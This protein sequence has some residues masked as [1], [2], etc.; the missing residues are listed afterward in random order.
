MSI[1]PCILSVG[2]DNLRSELPVYLFNK[3]WSS[4][5]IHREQESSFN[6]QRVKIPIHRFLLSE[7]GV[8]YLDIEL[9][10]N[11][12]RETFDTSITLR[13]CKQSL[14]TAFATGLSLYAIFVI[15]FHFCSSCSQ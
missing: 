2:I 1:A 7:Y 12:S 4:R 14:K 6:V 3:T 11:L 13:E 5:T 15:L 8:F 10:N 9:L